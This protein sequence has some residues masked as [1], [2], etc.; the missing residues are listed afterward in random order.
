MCEEA[1]G[2]SSLMEK[3]FNFTTFCI[4]FS[5][6]IINS[7]GLK[8]IYARNS[9]AKAIKDVQSEALAKEREFRPNTGTIINIPQSCKPGFVYEGTFHHR[10]RRI[11]G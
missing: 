2:I 11:A 3:K 8:V 10:C 9:T 1:H 6:L 5:L 4:I 7:D